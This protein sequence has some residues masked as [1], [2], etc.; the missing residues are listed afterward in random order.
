MSA[1][2]VFGGLLALVSGFFI[3]LAVFL[4]RTS[5]LTSGI[6]GQLIRWIINLVVCLLA[7]IGG[8]LAMASKGGGGGLTL[9]AGIMAFLM[10]L[11]ANLVN[12]LDL[13][14]YFIGYSGIYELTNY[15]Y[16]GLQ[17]IGSGILWSFKIEG[18]LIFLGAVIIL[19]SPDRR[20]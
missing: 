9:I 5:E 12:S 13:Q 10:P 14:Y 4:Y 8:V 18:F 11:I 3:L 2:K 7:I 20:N 19:N 17:I 15:A 16:G 1:G 6:E